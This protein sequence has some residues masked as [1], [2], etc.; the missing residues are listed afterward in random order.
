M[1]A[2]K[3]R[4]ATTVIDEE[5]GKKK[6]PS[7][8][9]SKKP[10]PA[11]QPASAKQ[12]KPMKKKPSKTTPSRKIRKGK[13]SDH[14]VDE[15]DEEPQL[16]FEPQVEDDEYNLQRGIQISLE[17]FQAPVGEVAIHAQSLLDLQKP[18]KK[19]ITEK[20]IFQRRTPATQDASTRPSAQP[21]DD[22]SS[23]EVCDT[24]SSADAET[25]AD[26]EKSTSKADTEIFN[27]DE[28]HGE[29]VSH[30]VA[31]EERSVELD[32][33]H[34]RSDPGKTPESRP[35]PERV[36]MEE[37]Q[38]GSNPGQSHVLTTE[39]HVHI[40]N[41]PSSSGTLSSMKNLDDAFTIGDQ[42]LNDNLTE[43]E[44]CKANVETEVESIVTEPIH[45]ASSS[46]PPLSTP[47]INLT[48]PKP[49][50]P[51]D[52]TTQAL[53]S[54]VYTLENHDMYSNIDKYVNEMFENGSYRSHPEALEASM[55]RE[56]REEFNEEIAKSRKRH[57]YNQDPPLPPTK[58]SDRKAL[59]GSSKKKP[60]SPS[61]QPIDDVRIP[62]DVH[63]SDLEDTGAAHLPKIKTRPDW[64]KP[65]PEE[66]APKTPEPD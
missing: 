28:E 48:P 23:N 50:S 15:A 47:I 8:S 53:S 26:T 22:T 43:E 17:Y 16:V 61:E 39:E 1:A 52:K 9:K 33:G 7:A 27:D 4:Q 46:A 13:R 66:E 30:I 29:E 55:D 14:L 63:L 21:Q 64:L 12:P 24:L 58:D 5:G 10:A 51:P 57:R 31:L 35:P 45:Q 60:A 11:K 42:F 18:K 59:S 65:L 44:P 20:Y 56:N 34:D 19:S 62:D 40:E 41:P 37:D 32:E 36:L 6:A 49:V 2:R 38:A 54:R 3:P 25:S